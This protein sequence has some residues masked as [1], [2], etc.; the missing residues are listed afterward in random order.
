MWRHWNWT[1]PQPTTTKKKKK[2]RIYYTRN[3]SS[4]TAAFPDHCSYQ[5]GEIFF[6]PT[7]FQ[8]VVN[9]EFT[10]C[11]SL[12]FSLSPSLSS[13]VCL[14]LTFM[15]SHNICVGALLCHVIAPKIIDYDSVDNVGTFKW[16]VIY[17]T[18]RKSS[19]ERGTAVS[20]KQCL[21]QGYFTWHWTQ[22][23]SRW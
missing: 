13:I 17:I 19:I 6:L 9:K 8:S 14:T 16:V 23:C 12:W 21:V 1:P 15:C 10:L 4:P 18:L 5:R 20:S 2:E 3:L 22:N 11:F 7:S